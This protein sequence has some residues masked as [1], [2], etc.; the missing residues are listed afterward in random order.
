MKLLLISLIA[1]TLLSC[2]KVP[3]EYGSGVSLCQPVYML[4][5]KYTYPDTF[6][7]H[8]DTFW[9][10]G[11]DRKNYTYCKEKLDEWRTYPG[12]EGVICVNYPPYQ[13]FERSRVVIGDIKTYPKIY[14]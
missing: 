13:F 11:R 2:S 8:T 5:D 6:Y 3:E 4:S 14:K 9:F 10:A 1:S 7:T 12:W